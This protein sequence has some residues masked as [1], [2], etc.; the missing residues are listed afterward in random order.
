MKHA[1]RGLTRIGNSGEEMP[2]A[3]NRVELSS[4]K[5]EFGL[6]IAR[7]IHEFDQATIDCWD[8]GRDEAFEIVKAAKPKEAWKGGG[9]AP[10][11]VASA[12]R[13]HHGHGRVELGDQQLRADPRAG[14]PLPRRRRPVPDRRCGRI[15][16]TR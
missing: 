1:V 7:I 9:A 4:E 11:I 10:G 2:R 6:P 12:R 16:P 8:F 14:E 5:D 3:E 13:H 15:R